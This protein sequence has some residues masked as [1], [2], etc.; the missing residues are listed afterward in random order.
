MTDLRA[1]TVIIG[2]GVAGL[3]TALQLARG[4][5]LAQGS[6][7]A[8][9][10][11]RCVVLS[12]GPLQPQHCTSSVSA[13]AWAQG[14]IAA[15]VGPDDHPTLHAQDT[16][17]AGAGLGDEHVARAITAAAP[18]AIDWVAGLGAA[19]DRE[20]DGALRLGLEGAHG[21]HRIVHADGDGTGRELLRALVRAARAHEGITVLEGARAQRILLDANGH[22]Q[23]LVVRAGG[24]TRVLAAGQV[25][26]ATGGVGGLYAQ[27]TN[28]L[29]SRGQGLAMAARVGARMRDME[30]VQFHPTALDVG[31]DPMP[32]ISEALRGAGA[33]LVLDDGQPLL[34]DPLAPRDVVSRAVHAARSAGQ[35]VFLDARQS[36]TPDID[37]RFPTVAATCRTMG[38]D[39]TADLIPVGAAAHYHMG[40]VAVDLRGRSS[41][42]GLWAVGE[43]ASTGLHGANR[44]ASNSLLEGLVCGRW[45][46]ED[47]CS[48]L[49]DG[50]R[51][52]AAPANR[53][54]PAHPTLRRLS[55]QNL[56]ELRR[57]MSQHVAVERDGV[58]LRQALS[59]L[60]GRVGDAGVEFVDDVTLVAFLVTQ[61]ALRREGSLGAHT[62]TDETHEENCRTS[63]V[64]YAA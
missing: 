25:V 62:R 3:T 38:I 58:G 9:G 59:C 18:Q 56:M 55:P 48:S 17:A 10:S 47:L 13:T 42:P 19:F 61:S 16:I 44:L 49:A 21:R 1:D 39:P 27:T 41:V 33:L 43:V 28:P 54:L 30:M 11:R 4:R 5:Q 29:G 40:G 23:G 24:R 15:A 14:G 26:L 35:G 53:P 50:G 52:P 34:A 8:Q 60:G 57:L 36:I 37:I 2:A 7:Q 63:Q 6:E 31:A 45:V 51:A 64:S 20:D 46:A 32:L 22:V 12:A